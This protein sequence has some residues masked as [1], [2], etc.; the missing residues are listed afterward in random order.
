MPV[1]ALVCGVAERRWT[2]YGLLMLRAFVDDSGR[3]DGP[4]LVLSGFVADV[5][6]WLAF[7]RDWQA[8]LDVSPSV[9]YFKMVDAMH[10]TGVFSG[11]KPEL[12]AYRVNKLVSV[13]LKHRPNAINVA[14][15]YAA[16]NRIVRPYL[17]ALQYSPAVERVVCNPYFHAFYTLITTVLNAELLLG[18]TGPVDFIFDEQGKEGLRVV[19]DY[20]PV[21]RDMVPLGA[22]RD[23]MVNEP[24]FQNDK[25]LQP[26][27]AADLMAWEMHDYIVSLARRASLDENVDLS[28]TLRR[29]HAVPVIDKKIG[30]DEC[31]AYVRAVQRFVDSNAWREL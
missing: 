16:F 13:I 7:S 10:G 1:C 22:V 12:V 8:E 27:Q 5:P 6:T 26:L 21:L 28:E 18:Y 4:A 20:W 31:M 14:L 25:I 23:M 29:L 24:I 2:G 19:R 15:S 17:E 11:H 3:G 30:S 9:E